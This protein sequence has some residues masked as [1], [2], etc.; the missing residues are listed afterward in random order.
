MSKPTEQ[1]NQDLI[2][3]VAMCMKGD[4]TLPKDTRSKQEKKESQSPYS[5]EQQMAAIKWLDKHIPGWSVDPI[6]QPQSVK[7]IDIDESDE[8]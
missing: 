4:G 8:E 3:Y 2:N 5:P 6:P 7:W 1:E